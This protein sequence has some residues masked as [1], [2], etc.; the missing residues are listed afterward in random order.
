M[1]PQNCN[2]DN[3]DQADAVRASAVGEL[4]VTPLGLES[5]GRSIGVDD[6]AGRR[7]CASSQSAEDRKNQELADKYKLYLD[8]NF[9]NVLD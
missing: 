8:T 3:L 9:F 6:D 4:A 2:V 1:T 5:V 7:A